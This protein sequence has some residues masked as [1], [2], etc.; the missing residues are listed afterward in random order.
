MLQSN[1]MKL[2]GMGFGLI[3]LFIFLFRAVLAFNFWHPDLMNH[4]DWGIRF[5][6]YGPAKF[7][8]ANVWSFTWPNQPPGTMYL[9]AGVRKVFEFVFWIFWMINIKIPAFP[10]GVIT[11]FES[12]LYPALLHLPAILAD[13]G[14]AYVIYLVFKNFLNKEN[15]GKAA[16]ILFLINPVIWYNSSFW[17][18]YDSVI[19]FFAIASFYFLLRKNLFWAV[20]FFALSIYTKASLL[21]FAPIFLIVLI[22]QSYKLKE[23]LKSFIFWAVLFAIITLPFSKGEPVEWLYYLYKDKIF[24]QQLH[25]ITANAFNIWSAIAGIH[26]R[27]E[28]QML[29]PLSY[30]LWGLILFAIA[31][32]Q[33]L[34]VVYKKQN[35]ESVVWSLAIAAFSS[36]MLLTNMHERY[37]YPLFPYL[38][39][40]VM[41]NKKLVPVYWMVSILSLLNMYNFWFHPRLDFLINIM[42]A[43][44]RMAP[45]ILGLVNFSLFIYLYNKWRKSY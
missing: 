29:G 39:I 7:Y 40:I 45:R 3:I 35:M 37:L 8:D 2:K 12:N 6:E 17:G 4:M 38:T 27:P 21:I 34:I 14:I 20:G 41:M 43:G 15:L 16:A 5:W 19:N 18:Q 31:Y 11:F 42:A 23:V 33:A 10:S 28:T 44:N 36:F 30:K 1:N 26:E 32:I 13:F 25:V 9:M 24:H 22:K